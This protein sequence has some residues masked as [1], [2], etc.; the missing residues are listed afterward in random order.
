MKCKVVQITRGVSSKHQKTNSTNCIKKDCL[1]SQSSIFFNLLLSIS[2]LLSVHQ[3]FV[4]YLGLHDKTVVLVEKKKLAEIKVSVLVDY[5][6]TIVNHSYYHR[7]PKNHECP[8]ALIS[9][10]LRGRRRLRRLF[11]NAIIV[12]EEV[13]VLEQTGLSRVICMTVCYEPSK[14]KA[15][16]CAQSTFLYPIKR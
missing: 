7:I 15:A 8:I 2:V 9:L 6:L 1:Y 10:S 12:E 3:I 16:F 11:S 4:Q 13:L 14:A 5:H